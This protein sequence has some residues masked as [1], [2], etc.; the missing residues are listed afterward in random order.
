MSTGVDGDGGVVEVD[1][2]LSCGVRS[3]VASGGRYQAWLPNLCQKTVL[4][5]ASSV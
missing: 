4:L 3:W 1:G 2:D 5:S